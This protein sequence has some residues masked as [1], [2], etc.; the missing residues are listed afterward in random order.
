MS[1]YTVEYETAIDAVAD[2]DLIRVYDTSGGD[3][4]SVTVAQMR[5]GLA[6]GLVD[7]TATTLAVTAASH[8]GKTVTIS[9]AA[10]IAVTMPAATGTGN[11][12]R[13]WIAVAATGTSHTIAALTTD[14]ISGYAFA[15]TTSTDNAEA[16]KTSATSDKVSLNGTTLGGVVGDVVEFIDVKSGVWSVMAFT[17]PTGTEATP[18]SAS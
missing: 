5:A 9:S 11:K 10:P 14:I 13:F 6:G 2:G 3:Y 17:A 8:A 15:V 16:F 7:T 18:F 12:Y 1:A 4:N